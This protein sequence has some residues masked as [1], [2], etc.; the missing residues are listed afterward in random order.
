M[1]AVPFGDYAANP[2]D[3]KQFFIELQNQAWIPGTRFDINGEYLRG[4][5]GYEDFNGLEKIRILNH[6]YF[7]V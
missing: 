5:P 3:F 7:V 2:G 6:G 4:F 1:R